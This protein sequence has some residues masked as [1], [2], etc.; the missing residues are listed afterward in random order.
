MT[1]IKGSGTENAS[2]EDLAKKSVATDNLNTEELP[3]PES[4]Q[5]EAD[6]HV[7]STLAL[8]RAQNSHAPV[9]LGMPA[10]GVRGKFYEPLARNFQRLGVS[11]ACADLRGIGTSSIRAS[12]KVNFGY[13]DMINRDYPAQINALKLYCAGSPLWLLGHSLGGQL[14]ALYMATHP[15]QIAGMILVSSCTVYYKNY[16]QSRRLWLST[17]GLRVF[18][19]LWG[20]LP[21]RRLGFG[22]TEARRVIRD[23]A[24]NARGG[25]YRLENSPLDYDKL[26]ARVR[27]PVLGVS[28]ETDH[29][30]PRKAVDH[31][32]RKMPNSHLERWHIADGE[33]S[34]Q[35][36]DHFNWVKD[37]E[38]L[39]QRIARWIEQNSSGNFSNF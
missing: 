24:R 22:G 15:E 20:Y 1:T 21:G 35:R 19:E 6:D 36:W 29:F 2:N 25:Q 38:A 7:S 8:Y 27:Q 28:L 34:S 5:V 16:E 3:A 31:L 23:W 32:C 30:A 13:A 11:Y 9:V 37:S 18:S 39:S 10:M 4:I 17:Q 33:L 14:N 26:L 12:R